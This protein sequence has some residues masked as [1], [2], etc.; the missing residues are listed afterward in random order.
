VI[1][2]TERKKGCGRLFVDNI[3]LMDS[4]KSSLKNFL[5]KAHDCGIKNEMT[6]G[7]SIYTILVVRPKN[8][9]PSRHYENHTFNLGMNHLPSNKLYTYFNESLNLE[10]IIAKMKNK[11]NN[12][13]NFFFLYF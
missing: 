11:L 9:I 1:I 4:T 10:V 12:T 13:V 6:F 2:C 7:I 8:F 3:I 5:N